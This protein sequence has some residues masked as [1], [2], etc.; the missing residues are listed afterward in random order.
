MIRVRRLPAERWRDYRDL[1]LESLK[2][3]PQA[4]G[5]SD[6]EEAELEESAWRERTEGALFATEGERP[7]GVMTLS[8][9][10]RIKTRHTAEIFGFYV[11]P[12]HRGKGVGTQ[13]L[14]E[15]LALVRSRKGMVK[16]RLYVNPEQRAAVKL[17]R[18]AGFRVAGRMEKELK[19]GDR[20]TRMLVM[21]LML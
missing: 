14:R 5:S 6:E 8:F 13:L 7:V 21:E 19:I 9:N 12:E 18:K 17:Y 15:G 10:D 16:V 11:R 4:F 1:R 3:E 20:F 2:T